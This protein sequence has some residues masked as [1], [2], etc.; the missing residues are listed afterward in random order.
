[1][2]KGGVVYISYDVNKE[3]LNNG[4]LLLLVINYDQKVGWYEGKPIRIRTFSA[5]NFLYINTWKFYV[6]YD[7]PLKIVLF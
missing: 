2:A 6:I 1:M 3:D 7:R 4:Y 5:E